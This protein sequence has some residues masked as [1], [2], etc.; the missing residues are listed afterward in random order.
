MA[1]RVWCGLAQTYAEYRS[2][3]PRWRPRLRNS[4]HDAFYVAMQCNDLGEEIAWEIESDD[5]TTFN[6]QQIAEAVG[7]RRP[8]LIANPPK[9]Y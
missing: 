1:F 6:R 7:L 4:L 5:G 9:K 2:M 3:K 8:E